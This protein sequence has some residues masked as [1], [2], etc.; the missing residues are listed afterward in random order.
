MIMEVKHSK[1]LVTNAE[2]IRELL[3]R[4]T[5]FAPP[6]EL[7]WRT[8]GQIARCAGNCAI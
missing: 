5:D 8:G 1:P 6:P 2:N 3:P 4:K 7:L